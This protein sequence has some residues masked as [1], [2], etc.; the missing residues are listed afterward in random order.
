MKRKIV[1]RPIGWQ[2]R[3][4]VGQMW[5]S[6]LGRAVPHHRRVSYQNVKLECGHW[7]ELAFHERKRVSLRCEECAS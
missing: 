3:T 6:N 1:H 5:R 2:T 7:A 4:V